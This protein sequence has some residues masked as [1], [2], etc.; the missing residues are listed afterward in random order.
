MSMERLGRPVQES[1]ADI[2]SP[3]SGD[4]VIDPVNLEED[5]LW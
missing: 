4:D 1:R 5:D 3:F 2:S